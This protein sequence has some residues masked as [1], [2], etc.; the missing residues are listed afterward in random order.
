[1]IKVDAIRSLS[2]KSAATLEN[3]IKVLSGL[4]ASFVL[5][6]TPEKVLIVSIF[7][8][9]SLTAVFCIWAFYHLQ[10]QIGK[11]AELRS[12]FIKRFL[13]TEARAE[14]LTKIHLERHK[15]DA[16]NFYDLEKKMWAEQYKSL[17]PDIACG[18]CEDK[19]PKP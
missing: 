5:M 2:M 15:E 6:A 4:W 19:R 7:V 17:Q 13:Q 3:F 14:L 9:M 8:V 16:G 18:S 1:M 10:R 11:E 12:L